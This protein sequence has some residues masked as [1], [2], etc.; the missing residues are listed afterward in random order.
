MHLV[1]LHRH[2]NN[3][4]QDLADTI[5][6]I[7][8]NIPKIQTALEIE[9]VSCFNGGRNVNTILHET[10]E[11]FWNYEYLQRCRFTVC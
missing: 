11:Y 7:W 6:Y 10:T 1:M 4:D 5:K 2:P 9:N 8:K 3:F